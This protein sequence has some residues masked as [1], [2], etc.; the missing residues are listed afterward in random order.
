MPR[1]IRVL[2][3]VNNLNYGGMERVVAQICRRIDQDRFEMHLTALEYLGHFAGEIDGRAELHLASPMSKWSM[4][5]PTALARDIRRIAP[6]VV[7]T[8]SGSWFKGSL[9]ARMAGVPLQLYT[10]HGRQ[11]PDPWTHRA[12]DRIASKRTDV[13][14]AV[15]DKLAQHLASFVA[16]ASRIRV[17]PNGVDTTR[18]SSNPVGTSLRNE[19]GIADERPIIGSIGRLEV[20]KGYEVTIAAFALLLSTWTNGAPP[21]LVLV[22]DGSQKSTLEQMARDSGIDSSVH[23]LGWR[24]DIQRC[25]A[26]YTIFEMSSH[27]EG[28]SVS[29]LEAMSAGLCPVVTDV[30]GNAAVLGGALRHRLVPPSDPAALAVAF[31]DAL[32]GTERRNA[33]ATAARERVVEDFG[34]ESM[35]RQYEEIYQSVT[36]DV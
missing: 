8:H 6:D 21:A 22:G 30:G 3:I 5:R 23:F 1:R 2:H 12:L 17:V 35:V 11:I 36:P 27:S 20:V 31:S 10:D 29:L 4:V 14:V 34:L 7:H 33:D 32:S 13:V 24:S 9:A 25:L 26:S 18:H 19:L 16:D 15:S 28:T